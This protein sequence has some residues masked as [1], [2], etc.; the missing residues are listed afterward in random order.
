M[1]LAK[2]GLQP[3]GRTAPAPAVVAA[4]RCAGV[5]LEDH[6]PR[7]AQSHDKICRKFWGSFCHDTHVKT[8]C[9][10]SHPAAPLLTDT[11]WLTVEPGT[12]ED[13]VAATAP[14]VTYIAP[15]SAMSMS[16]A[17]FGGIGRGV[18]SGRPAPHF[19]RSEPL[20]N[21]LEEDL[22]EIDDA[23]G[24]CGRR[25]S[26]KHMSSTGVRSRC[27]CGGFL[28]RTHDAMSVRD[29]TLRRC[30]T[31]ARMACSSLPWRSPCSR[32]PA[33]GGSRCP[34]QFHAREHHARCQRRWTLNQ[35]FGPWFGEASVL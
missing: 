25:T 22:T 26:W 19:D 11:R 5:P 2:L 21:I 34:T 35:Q 10:G 3:R 14:V 15:A 16:P 17:P 28:G 13:L 12:R 20:Y 32:A 31:S 7:Q 8:Q 24:R 30:P 9:C 4:L 23:L 29:F 33:V 6:T 27:R 1:F 18:D